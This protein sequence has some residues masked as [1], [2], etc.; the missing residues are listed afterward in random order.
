MQY[1]IEI[2]I[3]TLIMPLLKILQQKLVLSEQWTREKVQ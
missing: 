3:K 2:K 1:L